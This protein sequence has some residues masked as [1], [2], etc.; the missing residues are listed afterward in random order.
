MGY[1]KQ[2]KQALINHL[3]LER[4]RVAKQNE[5]ALQKATQQTY[6]KVVRRLN[7]VSVSLRQVTLKDVLQVERRKRLEARRLIKDIQELNKNLVK[8]KVM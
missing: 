8:Q 6:L 7:Q 1:T 3:K 4:S 2:E 5:E